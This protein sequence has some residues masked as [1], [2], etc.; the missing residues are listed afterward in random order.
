[1]QNNVEDCLMPAGTKQAWIQKLSFLI[2]IARY[3]NSFILA[4]PKFNSMIWGCQPQVGI[5]I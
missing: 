3:W 4:T 5:G 1:M 2:I